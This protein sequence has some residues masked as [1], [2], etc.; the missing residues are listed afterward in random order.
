MGDAARRQPQP[1][2]EI[3]PTTVQAFAHRENFPIAVDADPFAPG[4]ALMNV[5]EGLP[6]DSVE[7]RRD[8]GRRPAVRA[9]HW[10]SVFRAEMWIARLSEEP[11]AL[12]TDS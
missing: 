11:S 10:L 2:S 7:A 9:S 5:W 3:H 12:A 8:S 6:M 4:Y 1:G